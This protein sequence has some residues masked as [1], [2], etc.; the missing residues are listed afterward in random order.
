MNRGN[1]SP[2]VAFS[3]DGTHAL[4]TTTPPN[5][6]TQTLLNVIDLST[7][8]QPRQ[9]SLNGVVV[10]SPVFS[11]DGT[12][13]LI[14]LQT[15]TGLTA[16]DVDTST[17]TQIQRPINLGGTTNTT[18]NSVA[19][20]A[21]GTH[22][23]V[24][25][26]TP[27]G[28]NQNTQTNVTVIDTSTGT[29]AGHTVTLGGTIVGSPLY[30]A[31]G[32]HVV[33]TTQTSTNAQGI[34][35]HVNVSTVNTVTG[36]QTGSTITIAANATRTDTGATAVLNP[37][38][39]RVILTTA[40]SVTVI[41][42]GTGTQLGTTYTVNR[43]NSSPVVAFSP[44]GTHALI[45]T[46]PPNDTT[47]TL[48]NVIDLSTGAQPRQQSLN[49]VVVGSPVF[50]ADGTAALI[51]LQTSTGLTAADVDTSTGTQIQRPINLGGTTNT[52]V[53]S[54]ALN[55]DGTHAVVI[56]KTPAGPNQ[57]TQTNVTVVDTSTGTQ[58][59]HTVTLG[60]TIVGSPLY[61]AD[62][63]HVVITTQT[64]TNAQ[65]I[66]D[67]VNVSAVNTVTGAQTGSTITIAANATR[68]DTGATAVLNPTA[69][70]VILTTA[71]SVTVIDPSTGTQLGTTYTVNRGNSSPVVA[72]SPD[73]THALITTTPPNDTTRTA[74]SILL[75]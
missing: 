6:T 72:F 50:N 23:V 24:I 3:P 11:A 7:G 25:T 60:G 29:Q 2:V 41:D 62:G 66:P 53:N 22:A 37:T 1:S 68:T 61:S 14:I 8:A 19:L 43:G 32:T 52:T 69:T 27:A 35:D 5:D 36:A 70:R 45:T 74:L 59:G 49:G 34:P 67:H 16:A 71:N 47:Q 75:L 9:Q 31:D 55:A 63:T 21:D 44:D 40:N 30:S 15:S 73:G 38:A 65:G 18:V 12:A 54:V 39:T 42:P 48:L 51:I 26:K 46:T 56:T 58:A 13:A 17:G 4:I 28:P 33:I 57:N 10:G 20:N 64:S